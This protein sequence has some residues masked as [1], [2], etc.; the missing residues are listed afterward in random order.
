NRVV[1][2]AVG[3]VAMENAAD[4]GELDQLGKFSRLRRLDLTPV[5]AQLGLDVG[6]AQRSEK[7]GLARD[8]GRRLR[9]GERVLVQAPSSVQRAASNAD[10]VRDAPGEVVEREREFLLLHEPQVDRES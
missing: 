8:L 4:V 5:L 6:K 10:V 9:A 2:V 7:V 3:R 1:S